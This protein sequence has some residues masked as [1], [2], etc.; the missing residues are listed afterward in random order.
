MFSE[1][2]KKTRVCVRFSTVGEKRRGE[3]GREGG[4]EGEREREMKGGRKGWRGGRECGREGERYGGEIKGRMEGKKGIRSLYSVTSRLV[5][6]Y[7]S[8][9]GEWQC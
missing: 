4:R 3:G 8:R 6:P 9:W 7:A 5:P 2:G 1:I